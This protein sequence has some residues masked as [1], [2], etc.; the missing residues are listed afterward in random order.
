MLSVASTID[1]HSLIIGHVR[2][3]SNALHGFLSARRNYVPSISSNARDK[4]AR[5]ADFATRARSYVERD[6]KTSALQF[7]PDPEGPGRMAKALRQ[8]G[9]GLAL[10][11][12]AEA[13]EDV[14]LA[15]T[16]RVALDSMPVLRRRVLDRLAEVS[17]ADSEERIREIGKELRVSTST[18]RLALEDLEALGVVTRAKQGREDTWRLREE[19]VAVFAEPRDAS[20]RAVS[21]YEKSPHRSPPSPNRQV[22]VALCEVCRWPKPDAAIMKWDWR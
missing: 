1:A 5:I 7:A 10:G 13:V 8:L 15:I 12:D 6:G 4:L 16:L 17:L 11:D 9:R 18:V 19:H 2:A 3:L 20:R 21:F 22:R 14:H